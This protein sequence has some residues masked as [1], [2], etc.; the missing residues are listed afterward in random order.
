MLW[1]LRR[2]KAR[3]ERFG[4]VDKEEFG[5]RKPT[6]RI[7]WDRWESNQEARKSAFQGLTNRFLKRQRGIRKTL[8]FNSYS[9]FGQ[10]LGINGLQNNFPTVCFFQVLCHDAFVMATVWSTVWSAVKRTGPVIGS[11]SVT[12][13]SSEAP[14]DSGG[15]SV[16]WQ[17]DTPAMQKRMKIR[18][19]TFPANRF[20][21]MFP[22]SMAPYYDKGCGIVVG[23]KTSRI[24]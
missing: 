2:K 21:K 3:S 23:P 17:A 16:F 19:I 10:W 5:Q 22:F 24:S 11:P 9:A 15:C 6:R 8:S 12:V 4:A 20:T 7:E 18:Q 1:S 14:V 13:A